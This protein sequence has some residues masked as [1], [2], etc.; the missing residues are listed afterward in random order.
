MG[1]VRGCR[2][3]PIEHRFLGHQRVALQATF[4]RVSMHPEQQ[5]SAK[6]Q[7]LHVLRQDAHIMLV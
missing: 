3:L 5:G 4:A 2:R 6:F 1:C 7:E